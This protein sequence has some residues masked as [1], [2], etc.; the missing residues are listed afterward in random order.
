M[1]NFKQITLYLKLAAKY[2]PLNFWCCSQNTTPF[3]NGIQTKNFSTLPRFRVLD[4]LPAQRLERP[5]Q[6]FLHNFVYGTLACSAGL[7]S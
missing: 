7:I 5:S 4:S 1:F 3:P 2:L 6:G